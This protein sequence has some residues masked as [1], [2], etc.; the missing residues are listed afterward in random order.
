VNHRLRVAGYEGGSLFTQEALELLAKESHGIPRIINNFCFNALSLG[1]AEQ[2]PVIDASIMQR[3]A[4]DLDLEGVRPERA[5]KLPALELSGV[6]SGDARPVA[7]T[8]P[9]PVAVEVT[10]RYQPAPRSAGRKSF[11]MA[12]LRTRVLRLVPVSLLILSA[13]CF[14]FALLERYGF[15]KL[16]LTE[17]ISTKTTTDRRWLNEVG[18]RTLNGFVQELGAEVRNLLRRESKVRNSGDG[19]VLSE[20]QTSASGAEVISAGAREEPTPRLIT[21]L[22]SVTDL[23]PAPEW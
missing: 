5:A 4:A 22:R 11:G 12:G 18:K 13:S 15:S 16:T 6:S 7:P 2:Q 19:H 1:Y 17:V 21:A 8:L 20:R 9:A 3:V 23:S 14:A 10:A